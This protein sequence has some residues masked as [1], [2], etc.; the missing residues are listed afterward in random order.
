[1]K[2]KGCALLLA[3]IFAVPAAY[4]GNGH[5]LHGIGAVNSAM[6]G[7][8]V[9]LPIDPLGALLLNPALLADLDGSRFAF[10][11]E[12][13]TQKVAVESRVGPFSGRTEDETDPAVIPAFGWTH[14]TRGSRFAYGMGF[15]GLSGF[16]VDYPQ[17]PTN[18]LLSPQPNGFG[19]VYS[20]YLLMK[21]PVVV[22][23][24]LS[25]RVSLGLSFN[26][27]RATLTADPA[28]FATPDCSGPAGPCF[29]PKV[30]ADSAWGFGL[31]VCANFKL[32]DAFSLGLS[33]N[34]ETDFED[35]TFNSTVA[36]PNLPTFGRDRKIE[37]QLNAPAVLVAGIGWK[38]S[39]RLAIGIDGK[40]I[41]YENT[42]GFS[43]VLGFKDIT[44]FDVGAQW[45]A[46]PKLALRAGYNVSDN[47]IPADRAFLT[48][49]VPAIFE[50][51]VCAG[52]GIKVNPSL[53][54]NVGYYHVFENRITGPFLSPVIGPVPG[55]AVTTE[56]S[57]SA[58]LATFS[59][60]L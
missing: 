48:V 20:S 52:I 18:P 55:T 26:T 31:G 6:G 43:D 51:R 17:D 53:E 19:R 42:E 58:L 12:Y 11:A 36:N 27:A 28:G 16:G 40:W 32:S 44:V 7:A 56:I 8:G 5:N 60:H 13:N 23:W 33:Y 24:Q 30:N 15:L 4:A 59:F 34:T 9:A 41:S 22:A 29:F 49:A 45:Q 50:D 37:L 14:H 2:R 21:I 35:F 1:M 10:S 39:D 47:P 3:L 54:L 46:T 38:P 57:M 25:D